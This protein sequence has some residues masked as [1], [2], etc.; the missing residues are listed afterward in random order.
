MP[1][2]VDVLDEWIAPHDPLNADRNGYFRW[3]NGEWVVNFGKKK[4][5]TLRELAEADPG[6]LRWIVKGDF[7][8]DTRRIASDALAG[9]FPECPFPA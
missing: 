2:D 3:K 6:F 9:R 5:K 8:L 7:P 4:G 1:R